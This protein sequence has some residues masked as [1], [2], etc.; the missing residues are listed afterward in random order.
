MPE[1]SL[2][3]SCSKTCVS[4]HKLFKTNFTLI[5][6]TVAFCQLFIK[7]T[8]DGWMDGWMI[9]RDDFITA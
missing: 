6:Y 3:D 7:D 9:H 2:L 8:M 5:L 1:T 4:L